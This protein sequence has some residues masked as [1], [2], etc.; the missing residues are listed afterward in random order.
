[1]A[2]LRIEYGL[3]PPFHPIHADAQYAVPTVPIL[4]LNGGRTTTSAHA[5][6]GLVA[7]AAQLGLNYSRRQ[8]ISSAL[9]DIPT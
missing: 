8:R 7:V 3:Q 1:M 4:T 2:V 6:Q 9:A 5:L